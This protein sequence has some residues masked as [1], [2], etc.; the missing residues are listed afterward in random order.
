[1]EEQLS[2]A[3]T[4]AEAAT[5]VK[6]NF[7]AA[8]SHEIRTP[9]NGVLGMVDLLRQTE[10]TEEQRGMLQVI[11]ESGQSL[12]TIINDILD[13]SKIEA[14]RMEI[15]RIPAA[16]A[17]IVEGSARTVSPN[18]RRKGLRLITFIDPDL[19]SFVEGDPVRL[20]QILINLIGNAIKFTDSG[21]VVVRAERTGSEGGS[22]NVRFRVIDQGIGI[23]PEGRARLFQAFSQAESST[24][25]KYGGTGLGLSIC[26][27]LVAMMNGEI[28]VESE[29]GKGSE[30]WVRL[31]FPVVRRETEG[32]K[33]RD[34]AGVRVLMLVDN[35]EE[36]EICRRYLEFW[37]AAVTIHRRV[38]DVAA[39]WK[40]AAAKQRPHHV[41]VHGPWSSLDRNT[42]LRESLRAQGCE[43]LKFVVLFKGR[44]SSARLAAPDTVC[45]DVD[46]LRRSTFLSA[47]AIAM[48]RASPEVHHEEAHEDLRAAGGP[49]TVGEAARQ[50]R[51]ILVA[52]DNETNRD[53]IRRQLNLLGFACELANDGK[54]ALQ[55]WRSGRHA[56]LLTDCHMPRMDGFELTDAIRREE[57]G[58]GRRTPIVAI[59]ANALQGEADRCLAAGM[60][61]YLSKPIDLKLLRQSL[62]RWLPA[63]DEGK[64]GIAPGAAVAATRAPRGNGGA[65]DESALRSVF[66]DDPA[67][68]K[69]ILDGFVG[70]SRRIV[71]EI[72]GGCSRRSAG[73]VKAAAHKLKSS[74]R[75]IGAYALADLCTELEAAGGEGDWGKIDDR[76]SNL[77]TLMREVEEY[78]AGL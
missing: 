77:D 14:G 52:E 75:S 74:A 19:P 5:R 31:S 7:L 16:L 27:R 39:L 10:V 15:E 6:A 46:P 62:V 65:I 11:S 59:T 45:V 63:Q 20:R 57:R 66:G 37:N 73:E 28:G 36:A 33:V 22:V 18:A 48:G 67:V 49:P 51:L 24:T 41:L 42:G 29:L 55:A 44:R 76:A 54:D 32:E 8:M 56:V 61:D 47:V 58:G 30:F 60:D 34:L 43:G 4:A 25:R 23:S 50:G 40:E 72:K 1:M 69:E 26:Q 38:D 70:P 3:K 2:R 68:F 17:D 35:P 71:A 64:A 9:M 53:V 21:S 78:I 12:L 13:L